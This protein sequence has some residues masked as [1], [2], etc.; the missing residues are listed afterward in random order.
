MLQVNE[1]PQVPGLDSFNRINRIPPYVFKDV[2]RQDTPHAIF[3]TLFST[4]VTPGQRGW[5]PPVTGCTVNNAWGDHSDLFQSAPLLGA[6]GGTHHGEKCLAGRLGAHGLTMAIG[7]A[8]GR[9]LR[10]ALLRKLH[11]DFA[12]RRVLTRDLDTAMNRTRQIFVSGVNGSTATR[13]RNTL[14][15]RIITSCR[16]L[17]NLTTQG[18]HI[19]SCLKAGNGGTASRLKDVQHARTLLGLTLR[20]FSLH[21]NTNGILGLP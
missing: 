19:N 1:H 14:K 9:R 3:R 2:R 12:P 21:V 13:N 7:I 20:L 11:Q 18:G 15:R 17:T 10:D 8:N 6:P 4:R 16:S 5:I